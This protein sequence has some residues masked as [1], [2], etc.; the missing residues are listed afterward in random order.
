MASDLE[1]YVISKLEEL[2]N[3]DPTSSGYQTEELHTVKVISTL[4]ETL[5]REDINENACK[6][7]L[8]KIN[9]EVRKIDCEREIAMTKI[10]TEVE[11]NDKVLELENKKIDN[12]Y[13]LDVKKL[14]NEITKINID[15]AKVDNDRE[16]NE[17]K[18]NCDVVKNKQEMIKINND[19]E[20]NIQ[21]IQVET[22][23]NENNNVLESS[24]LNHAIN[25]DKSNL[26][27]KT[28]ELE[29]NKRSVDSL[30]GEKIA[31]VLIDGAA[32]VQR[33]AKPRGGAKL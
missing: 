21:K 7:N 28:K 30:K 17:K 32:V 22:E 5:Q 13:D 23:K 6:V 19:Y 27:L 16:I 10:E 33:D 3:L 9:N 8:E 1:K 20:V 12:S 11:K 18:I 26:K 15:K 31:K 2:D 24:K 25:N 29:L 14:D 4:V